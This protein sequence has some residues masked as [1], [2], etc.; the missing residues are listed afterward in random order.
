MLGGRL[1]PLPPTGCAH[2]CSQPSLALPAWLPGGLPH[3]Q[4][5]APPTPG[6]HAHTSSSFSIHQHI[7]GLEAA[8][9]MAESAATSR[10]GPL[11]AEVPLQTW[12]PLLALPLQA[13]KPLQARAAKHSSKSTM[14]IARS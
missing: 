4:A 1:G 2:G 8:G 14:A 7:Q 11:Q 12:E 9:W 10:R 6:P 3:T 13:I 5:P